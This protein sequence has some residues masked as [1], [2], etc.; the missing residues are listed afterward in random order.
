MPIRVTAGL[1]RKDGRMLIARRA[2]GD[3]LAGKWE[4][5]GGKI[6]P[7]E[8]AEDCLARELHEEFE[9]VVRV[10]R[11]LGSNVHAYDDKTVELLFFDVE[12]VSGELTLHAHDSAAWVAV[13][14]LSA[15]E[16]APADIPFVRKLQ[17]SGKL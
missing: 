4:L 1:I 16:F 8:M 10:G 17:A 6:E 14:E 7:G 13:G 12:Y 2:P 11:P 15:Y 3:R 5:P 9:I